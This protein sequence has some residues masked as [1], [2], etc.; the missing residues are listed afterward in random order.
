[1]YTYYL[2]KLLTTEPMGLL[3]QQNYW[4]GLIQTGLDCQNSKPFVEI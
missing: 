4:S 3:H 1:M 2:L